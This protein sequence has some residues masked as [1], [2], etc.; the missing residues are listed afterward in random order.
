MEIKF[1]DEDLDVLETDTTQ[2]GSYPPGIAKAFRKRVAWIRFSTTEKDLRGIPG[3]RFE[4]LQGDR[5]HQHSMRLNDQWRLIM[6]IRDEA[7]RKIVH[8]IGIE[9]YH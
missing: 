2:D 8:L 7:G 6:E 4:K 9:D 1:D 3:Y 5:A